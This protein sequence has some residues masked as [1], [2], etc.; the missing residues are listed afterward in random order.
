MNLEE[1]TDAMVELA[2]NRERRE[3]M[4]ENGYRRVMSKYRIEDMRKT[5]Y[6]IYYDFCGKSDGTWSE[7]AFTV[8]G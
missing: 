8:T 5:Y 6:E 3:Q 7:E 4:G 2:R 1:I